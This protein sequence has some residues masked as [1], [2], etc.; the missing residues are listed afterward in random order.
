MTH[1][2]TKAERAEWRR[3]AAL[4]AAILAENWTDRR[5][6]GRPTPERR[7]RG[8]FVL[9]DGDE[10]GVAIAVDAAATM[11]DQL[12][13]AGLISDLQAQAGH[14]LA[15]LIDRTQ[16]GPPLRSCL[17]FAPRGHTGDRPPTHGELRDLA[18]RAALIRITGAAGWALLR[19]VVLE[20]RA[21]TGTGNLGRLRAG[22]DAV[23]AFWRLD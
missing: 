6:K 15:A 17:D 8:A 19:A 13:L 10:A 21:P 12:R 20:Q 11:L 3:R 23:A 22:L 4:S 7:R 16:I 5:D 14:D 9:I 1:H 18:E 2:G